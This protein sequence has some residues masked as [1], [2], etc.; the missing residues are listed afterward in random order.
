M[1]DRDELELLHDGWCRGMGGGGDPMLLLISIL[2]CANA[3]AIT[4]ALARARSL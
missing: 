3:Y 4:F 2:V 1:H